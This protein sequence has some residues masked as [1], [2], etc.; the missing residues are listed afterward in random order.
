MNILK[1]M[2]NTTL[3]V[4]FA[5]VFIFV[6]I[7]TVIGP[8]MAFSDI[9]TMLQYGTP[10]G[11]LYLFMVSM[12][13]FILYLSVRVPAFQVYYRMIPILWP[14][15]QLALFMFIGIGIAATIINYWAEYN[16]P[17]RGFAISLGIL[18]VLCVRVFMSWWFYK[19]PLAPIHQSGEGFE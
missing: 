1:K 8:L 15:L 12:C 7:T 17:S 5:P 6:A 11:G 18:S 19:N 9:R 4:G 10:N 14:I 13:C 2:M 3:G 16:I